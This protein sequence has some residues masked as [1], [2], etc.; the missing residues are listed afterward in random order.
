MKNYLVTLVT[1]ILLFI[2]Q[3]VFAQVNDP[4]LQIFVSTGIELQDLHWSISGNTNGANPNILSELKWTKVK[5]T[6]TAADVSWKF[7][8]RFSFVGGYSRAF[9]YSGLVNDIDYSGDNRT[10][11][12]YTGNFHNDKGFTDA[13]YLGGG[14]LLVN[15]SK[16]RMTPAAGYGTNRQYL[17]ITDP[18]GQFPGLNSS[19]ITSWRGPFLKN[20]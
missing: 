17:Y 15:S 16:F 3:R 13:W 12:V 2:G 7:W 9:T 10:N 11:P 20:K 8:R 18:S 19:Y 14:Y 6:V 4:K 1:A 5:G